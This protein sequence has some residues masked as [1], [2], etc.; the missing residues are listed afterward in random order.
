[1]GALN[2]PGLPIRAALALIELN[3]IILSLLNLKRHGNSIGRPLDVIESAHKAPWPP[4][5]HSGGGRA[6][7]DFIGYVWVT[8]RF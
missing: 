3:I 7:C 1:M 8:Q 5:G 2:D 4:M 6:Q